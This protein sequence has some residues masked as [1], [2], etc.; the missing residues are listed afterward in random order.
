MEENTI[1][2]NLIGA[3]GTGKSTTGAYL[4]ALMKNLKMDVELVTEYAKDLTW[5]IRHETMRNQ[6]YIFGKQHQRLF[7][8][9]NKVK[10]IVTDSPLLLSEFYSREY[11]DA[12][13]NFKNLLLEE[14]N[15]FNNIN[16]F[17]NRVKEYNPKGRNQTEEEANGFSI[18]IK[19]LLD[20]LNFKY[21]TYDAH[22]EVAH[23]ILEYIQKNGQ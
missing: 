6:L 18:R 13:V 16:I 21:V 14:V 9:K 12:S 15:K 10:Y 23:E 4:F 19:S 20:E 5:E 7:R 1:I 8:L 2:I 22:G 3:P 17:L 11:G